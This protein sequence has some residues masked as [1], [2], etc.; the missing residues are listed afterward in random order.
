MLIPSNP[1]HV[2]FLVLVYLAQNSYGSV[3]LSLQ[4]GIVLV[5]LENPE[6]E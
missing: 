5:S 6:D 3:V 2:Q 1:N 4:W